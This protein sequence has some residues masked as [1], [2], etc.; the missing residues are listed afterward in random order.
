MSIFA[1]REVADN[2]NT[3]INQGQRLIWHVLTLTVQVHVSA[4]QDMDEAIDEIEAQVRTLLLADVTLDGLSED[5]RWVST[6]IELSG[7]GVKPT[8][9]A[10]IVFEIFF[11][12]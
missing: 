6:D 2:D 1:N 3:A 4:N 5:L 9:I 11:R 12:N 8:A 7:G 10:D